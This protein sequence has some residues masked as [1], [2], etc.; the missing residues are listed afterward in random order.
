MGLS[1]PFGPPGTA[2]WLAGSDG[3]IF[4]FGGAA[5]YGSMG[6]KPLNKPIVGIA[7]TLDGCGYWEVASD[8]GI[9]NFGDRQLLRLDGRATAQQADRRHRRR[10][11][12]QRLLGGCLRWRHLQLRRRRLPGLDGR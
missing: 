10:A 7:Q 9:F 6:G 5:F 12:R 4:N 11:G 8:G 2:Y 1:F 3:G